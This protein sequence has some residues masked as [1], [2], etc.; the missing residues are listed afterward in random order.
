MKTIF[1]ILN[2]KTYVDTIRLTNELLLNDLEDRLIVVVDNASPNESFNVLSTTFKNVKKVEVISS[3]CNEGYAKGNNFGLNFAKRYNPQYICIINNDVYFD[4]SV[5]RKLED[6][7]ESIPNVAFLVPVQYNIHNQPASFVNLKKIPTFWDDLKATLGLR[8]SKH[9][10]RNDVKIEDL[11]EVEIVPGAFLFISFPLFQKLGFFY[12]GTFLFCEER[13]IAKKVK[14]NQL[15]SYILLNEHY[16]HAHSVTINSEA[17]KK[18]QRK[19]LVDGKILYAKC[20]R[21]FPALKVKLLQ[22]IYYLTIPL[23]VIKSIFHKCVKLLA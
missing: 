18:R 7:Y 12:E 1:L 3:P 17:S 4:F 10:Y 5:I 19:L 21:K 22:V 2:Y 11:Q 15:H 9:I 23:W 6:L 13:F 8:S 20:Y 14:D 16:I